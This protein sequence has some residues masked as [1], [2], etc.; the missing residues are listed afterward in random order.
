MVL[1]CGG[2]CE[3]GGQG[4]ELRFPEF[5][6]LRDPAGGLLHGL[7]V[8]AEAV[9]AAV[10]FA[11]E[12]AG[13]FEDAEVLGNGG[14]RHA[15]RFGEIGD[16]G[17]TEGETGKDGAAGRVGKGGEGGVELGETFNHMV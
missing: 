14:K 2:A 7:G 11:T 8:E 10:N 6:I 4:I 9:D 3:I 5:A 15:E 1:L 17:F 12:Q 13:G 16:V